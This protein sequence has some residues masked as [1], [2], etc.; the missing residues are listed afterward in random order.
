MFFSIAICPCAPRM[1]LPITD[2]VYNLLIPAGRQCDRN[3]RRSLKKVSLSALNGMRRQRISPIS[4]RIHMP[5][6][7]ESA[8][9]KSSRHGH[10]NPKIVPSSAGPVPLRLWLCTVFLN[11]HC[12]THDQRTGTG[13]PIL[14]KQEIV[15]AP[16]SKPLPPSRSSLPTAHPQ[17]SAASRGS[18]LPER[19]QRKLTPGP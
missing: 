6:F 3:P 8:F 18:V 11:D 1:H 7:A 16:A 15:L 9:P 13:H 14:T 17:P 19:I 12:L 4:K 10:P 5:S 2:R